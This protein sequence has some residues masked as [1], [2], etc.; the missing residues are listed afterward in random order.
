MVILNYY[1]SFQQELQDQL[2]TSHLIIQTCLQKKV[3]CRIRHWYSM[4]N[5]INYYYHSYKKNQNC[6]KNLSG[7]Y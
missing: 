1:E 5:S 3:Q 7:Y 2:I 4:I 6:F